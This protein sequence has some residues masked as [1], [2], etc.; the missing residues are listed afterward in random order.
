MMKTYHVICQET[1]Y[2]TVELEAE[3][4]SQAHELVHTNINKY[5]V[6]SEGVSEW[7]VDEIRE[8]VIT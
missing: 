3:N 5:P 1:V 4:V 2:F 7:N 6:I 8:K